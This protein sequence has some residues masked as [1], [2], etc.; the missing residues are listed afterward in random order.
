M[1]VAPGALV[2]A[3]LSVRVWPTVSDAVG[4]VSV[5]AVSAGGSAS[6]VNCAVDV[7]PPLVVAVMVALPAETA[8]T[9]QLL[10]LLDAVAT[11]VDELLHEDSVGVG[12]PPVIDTANDVLTPTFTVADVGA[13]LT[14]TAGGFC[15]TIPSPP[16]PHAA[17]SASTATWRRRSGASHAREGCSTA[18]PRAAESRTAESRTAAASD[19][20]SRRKARRIIEA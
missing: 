13:M 6:T 3:A 5:N 10:P 9:A 15:C 20:C 18:G 12:D 16:P 11:A 1:T 19:G 14:T 8:V 7:W 2:G 17:N 4:G